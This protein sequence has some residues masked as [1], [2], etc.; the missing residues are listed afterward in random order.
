[1]FSRIFFQGMNTSAMRCCLEPIKDLAKMLK[2]HAQ[3]ILPFIESKLTN[4]MAEGINRVIEIIKNRASGYANLC[5]FTD[6]I[7][8]TVGDIDLLAQI[9]PEFRTL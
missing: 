7:F 2:R 5:A 4:A 8:L 9:S 3:R 1:M 6:I